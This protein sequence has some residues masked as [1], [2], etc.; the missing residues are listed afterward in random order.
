MSALTRFV[1][2]G[3]TSPNGSS[4]GLHF[5]R[6]LYLLF[7]LLLVTG[8]LAGAQNTRLVYEPDVPIDAGGAVRFLEERVDG[9]LTKRADF[10]SPGICLDFV[11]RRN[12]DGTLRRL[13][14]FYEGDPAAGN[15]II[16]E[17]SSRPD[18]TWTLVGLLNYSGGNLVRARFYD[19]ETVR[20]ERRYEYDSAGVTKELI[21]APSENS[22]TLLSFVRPDAHIVEAYERQT[23][24][25]ELLIAKLKYDQ[26][27]RLLSEER[28]VKGKLDKRD[29]YAYDANGKLVDHI[30]YDNREL[31]VRHAM[32]GYSDD[33]VP[34]SVVHL[35]AKQRV[36]FG[37]SYSR[38]LD[39]ENSKT[40]ISNSSGEV[41]GTIEYRRENGLDVSRTETFLLGDGELKI[42]YTDFDVKGNWLRKETLT[43]T[44]G[45][46]KSRTVTTR[47]IRYF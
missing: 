24:G 34:K 20:D 18:G 35:D 25:R 29:V 33:G 17:Q 2:Y 10:L 9:E 37:L 11:Q 36:L 38:R 30:K 15:Y 41:T 1:F 32:Y 27:G 39:G 21:L 26:E 3:D 14:W 40:V 7:C 6:L 8:V 46:L 28:F 16:E 45:S 22:A 5:Y 13:S 23:D 12:A 4:N 47:V 43:Y 44:G 42:V 19:G 31:P